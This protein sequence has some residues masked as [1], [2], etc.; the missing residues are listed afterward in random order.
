M[1]ADITA[2]GH[3]KGGMTSKK[4][5]LKDRNQP[6]VIVSARKVQPASPRYSNTTYTRDTPNRSISPFKPHGP[7]Q[8]SELKDE[9]LRRMLF[10]S[11]ETDLK[12]NSPQKR[13]EHR[14]PSPVG[15]FNHIM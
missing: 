4:R 9:E 15:Y 6:T 7:Q 3:K 8:H 11:Q 1:R 14:N 10:A 5:V 12:E 13:F 2:S